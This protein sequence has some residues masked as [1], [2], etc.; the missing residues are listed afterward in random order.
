MSADRNLEPTARLKALA[1]MM[2]FGHDLFKVKDL[3]EAASFAVNSSQS[4]LNFTSAVFVELTGGK[5]QV[6]AQYSQ[7]VLN[8]H[9]ASA[10]LA[11]ALCEKLELKDGE[12]KE[13]PPESIPAGLGFSDSV[14]AALR[15]KP[16]ASMEKSG[17]RYIW[18]TEYK[19][20]IP[21]YAINSMNLLSS[22]IA[23]GFYF[24]LALRHSRW[25]TKKRFSPKL[26]FRLILLLLLLGTM[27][28][29]VPES[30]NAEFSLTAPEVIST[31]AWFDGPIQECLRQDSEAVK[32]GDIIAKYDTEQLQYRLDAAESALHEIDSELEVEDRTSFSDK[33]RL[34]ELKLLRAKLTSAQIA[35]DEAKWYLDHSVLK[36]PA[37]GI[38]VL[39]DGR[40]EHLTGKAVRTGDPVFDIY[41]GQGMIAEIAVNERDASIFR[42]TPEVVLFL[43]SAPQTPI[44]AEILEIAQYP[45]LTEQRTYCYIIRVK[46]PDDMEGKYRYGMRGIAR[47]TG[48]KVFLGYYLFKNILLY[49]RGL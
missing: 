47:L 17:T 9:A 33:A 28:L 46:L 8:P 44:A 38:L 4:L 2:K 10:K 3:P 48:E 13:L 20:T 23:E 12:L 43:H 30:T 6:L 36:A 37:D 11:C 25:N 21:P 29:K 7:V 24:Y 27:L 26:I 15:L 45:E 42:K 18:L 39:A 5:A 14:F 19:Q 41:T 32:K 16:P 1:V 49:L 35:V 40:A 34:G 31:Y 22:V